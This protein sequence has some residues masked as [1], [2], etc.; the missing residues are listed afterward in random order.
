[1]L[2][3]GH[4]MTGQRWKSSSSAGQG[5]IGPPRKN[6]R[7]ALQSTLTQDDTCFSMHLKADKY[8]F[9]HLVQ[10]TLCWCLFWVVHILTVACCCVGDLAPAH[11]FEMDSFHCIWCRAAFDP[12]NDRNLCHHHKQQSKFRHSILWRQLKSSG[13]CKLS[14]ASE[15]N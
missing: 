12:R 1:M 4:Q 7:Q 14:P 13:T 6:S 5:R 11:K 2:Q 10:P 15:R 9:K 3:T 8:L